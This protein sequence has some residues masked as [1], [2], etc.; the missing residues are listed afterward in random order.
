MNDKIEEFEGLRGVLALWVLAFHILAISGIHCIALMDG[1][2]AVSVFFAL[3]GF[4]IAKLLDTKHE[5]Y[6]CFILRRFFRLFPAYC[7][8]VLLAVILVLS[9]VMPKTFTDGTMG[10]HAILHGL[11]L[12]GVVPKALLADAEGAF[13][14][15]AWSVSRSHRCFSRASRVGFLGSLDSRLGRTSQYLSWKKAGIKGAKGRSFEPAESG[16][17]GIAGSDA[18]SSS[19]FTVQVVVGQR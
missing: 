3:S 13:L 2:H 8:C 10:F 12:H 19:S 6:G 7:L 4:V 11:M 18:P 16:A 15:P 14:N 5:P 1:R 17:S 9:G